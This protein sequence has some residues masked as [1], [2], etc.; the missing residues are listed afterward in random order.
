MPEGD[1][2]L[3]SKFSRP[4]DPPAKLP[5]SLRT[6]LQ[7]LTTDDAQAA[8][9][10]AMD[11]TMV[12]TVIRDLESDL[13]RLGPDLATLV[14]VGA[15]CARKLD[16]GEVDFVSLATDRLSVLV[17]ALTAEYFLVVVLRAG[18][19][20]ARVRLTIKKRRSELVELLP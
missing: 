5:M 17:M 18:G 16:G 2:T 19:N 13:G 9:V 4:R 6:V 7:E 14:K 1:I 10:G 11:G 15:Y 3:A 8:A 20:V 12:Q